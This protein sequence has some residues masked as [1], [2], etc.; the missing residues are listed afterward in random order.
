MVSFI[1]S[2]CFL[3]AEFLYKI[4]PFNSA[5]D[6]SVKNSEQFI[7]PIKEI[8]LQTEGCLVSTEVVSLFTQVSME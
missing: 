3:L 1:V 6:S 2:S 5:I 8:D 4:S 7:K